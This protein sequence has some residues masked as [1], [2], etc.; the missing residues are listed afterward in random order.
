MRAHSFQ[1]FY[2]EEDNQD[3]ER[4]LRHQMSSGF[5]TQH[6]DS[7][8]EPNYGG[9]SIELRTMCPTNSTETDPEA[10]LLQRTESEQQHD[11]D[12]RTNLAY[13]R[14]V[15]ARSPSYRK[16]QDRVSLISTRSSD[17]DALQETVKKLSDTDDLSMLAVQSIVDYSTTMLPA[18]TSAPP[19][20]IAQHSTENASFPKCTPR[21]ARHRSRSG[22]LSLSDQSLNTLSNDQDDLMTNQS[23]LREELLNCDQKELFQFLSEDYDTSNNYFSDTVGY[24]SGLLDADTDSL[25]L[26]HSGAERLARDDPLLHVTQTP[27]RKTSSSSLRSNLSYLSNS[28][29]AALEQ[30]RGGSIS[31]SIDRMLTRSASNSRGLPGSGGGGGAGGNGGSS[32][33]DD[34][35]P[36]VCDSDFEN[37]IASFEKEL[38]EIKKSTPSLHRQLSSS[39]S[40]D[41]RS[42]AAIP[43]QHPTS[44]ALVAGD[45]SGRTAQHRRT[46]SNASHM[47]VGTPA[48]ERVVLAPRRAHTLGSSHAHRESVKLKRRSLEKQRN[49]DDGYSV[50]H[51]I[52]KICDQMHAPFQATL[53]AKAKHVS[54]PNGKKSPVAPSTTTGV[55]LPGGSPGNGVSPRM[56][57]KSEFQNS[58]ERIK[59][60]SLIERVDEATD[61]EQLLDK[62]TALPD[63]V[64][65]EKLPRKFMPAAERTLDSVSLKSTGSYENMFSYRQP[66]RGSD[67]FQAC[68]SVEGKASGSGGDAATDEHG[69][70]KG[71]LFYSLCFWFS[72]E[73]FYEYKVNNR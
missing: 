22:L 27:P 42:D 49:I 37:I 32:G 63:R 20:I 7:R 55:V 33:S 30:R 12:A 72:R 35:E 3:A 13:Q 69:S 17:E 50:S 1:S 4:K 58:F 9:E 5:G 43:Q 66:P 57:R 21:T 46:S 40:E 64:V 25:V 11:R 59:R 16:S 53:D 44:I 65:S 14:S 26:D 2:S 62:P 34:R 31:E 52:R 23:N 24:S 45:G 60:T 8:D 28:I 6:N 48:L 47:L 73:S 29:F 51:E 18:T 68:N 41:D 70:K 61:E 71:A 10:P 67:R 36:L 38:H 54:R 19:A 15:L 39:S 56:R